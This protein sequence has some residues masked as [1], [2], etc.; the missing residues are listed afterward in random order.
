ME[1]R[2]E[3]L[4]NTV[5]ALGGGPEETEHCTGEATP[6]PLDVRQDHNEE[7][8]LVTTSGGR[9]SDIPEADGDLGNTAYDVCQ[10]H[11]EID[12]KNY[13]RY[14][15]FQ[16]V[17]QLCGAIAHVA[18]PL[19]PREWNAFPEGLQAVRGELNKLRKAAA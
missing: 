10:R 9:L 11:K 12:G 16:N 15:C 14:G 5:A 13:V 3:D 8:V 19:G 1:Q 18:L 6:L 7:Q 17:D 2:M 4:E